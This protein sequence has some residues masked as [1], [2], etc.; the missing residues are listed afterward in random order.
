MPLGDACAAIAT[1]AEEGK[2]KNRLPARSERTNER[3]S[4]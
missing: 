1:A 4:E 2:R 3:A